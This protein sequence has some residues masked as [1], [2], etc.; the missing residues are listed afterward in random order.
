MVERPNEWALRY[1]DGAGCREAHALPLFEPDDHVA[2]I[3]CPC[4]PT[5]VPSADAQILIVDH[6][7]AIQRYAVPDACP[8]F[9]APGD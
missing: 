3:F 6:R 4:S 1:V 5:L 2:S 8:E 7:S 9:P